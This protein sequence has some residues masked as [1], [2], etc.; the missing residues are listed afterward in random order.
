M[1]EIKKL[2]L[3]KEE[4]VSTFIG[5]INRTSVYSDAMTEEASESF[6]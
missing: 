4:V 2:K 1:D 6:V 3:E 5:N